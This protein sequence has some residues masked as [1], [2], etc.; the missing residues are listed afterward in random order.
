MKSRVFLRLV[1]WLIIAGWPSLLWS[2]LPRNE[3]KFGFHFRGKFQKNAK[4]R[5]DLIANLIVVKA[6]ID[7]SDTLNFILDTGVSSIIIT[8]PSLAK[9]LKLAFSRQVKISGAGEKEFISASVSVGHKVELGFVKAE[10]QN[11]V[12]LDED[13]LKLS[14]YMGIPIHGIFGH[15]LF[16]RFVI[17]VD[18]ATRNLILYDPATYKLKKSDGDK[19]PIVV[20]NSKP[21]LQHVEVAQKNAPYKA[22][23]LIIDTGAGHALMLNTQENSPISLPEKVIHANLGRGLNGAIDGHIGRID[24]FKIGKY[25]FSQVLASFPDSLSFSLKFS[26]STGSRHGSI[27]G[28]LLR[29]F[30]LT[31]H[32][33]ENYIVLKPIKDKYKET[34]EHDMSGMDVRARGKNMDEYFIS[35]VSPGSQADK[36]GVKENDQILFFNNLHY[37]SITINEIYKQLTKKEGKEV[38]LFIRRDNQVQFIYFKLKKEI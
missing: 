14:E 7:D 17:K 35:Y 20:T 19:F 1:L 28:E 4:I 9:K 22:V 13:I 32:Y 26:D 24:K 36:A 37:K 34:F 12:V 3:E 30:V 23:N 6:K 2:Q 11:L 16:S 31:F 15:D 29:R 18:F 27:G 10:K 21:Y 25:E 5:F 38:V 8:D 33:Q